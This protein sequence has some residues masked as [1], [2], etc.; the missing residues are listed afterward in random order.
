MTG[1]RALFLDR[2]GVINVDHG[3]VGTADRF[4]FMDGIFPLA[5]AAVADGW[6]LTVVTNQSGIARGYYS[7]ADFQA[8]TRHMLAGFAAH[9]VQLTAVLHC[10]FHRGGAAAAYAR[11]SFWRKPNP[12]MIL[13]A[14]R[15]FGFDLA[16]SAMIGDTAADMAAA[17]AAGVGLRLRLGQDGGGKDGGG[18]DGG[19]VAIARP[20]D[21]IPFLAARR[22]AIMRP[23]PL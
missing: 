19:V 13:E 20:D 6:R 9:G 18:A 5:R 15:R 2:D 10:P 12:G 14:A 16:R 23:G 11:D 1:E 22:A 17:L 8:V 7:E 3:Y 4:E 21:A